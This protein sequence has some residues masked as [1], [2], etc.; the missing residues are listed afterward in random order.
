MTETPKTPDAEGVV[1]IVER[2]T[3]DN[4]L[5]LIAMLAAGALVGAMFVYWYVNTYQARNMVESE[6]EPGDA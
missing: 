2:I 6:G 4:P 3:E 5:L 1:E